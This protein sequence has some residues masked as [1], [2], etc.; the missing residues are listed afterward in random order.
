MSLRR[1]LIKL[2]IL[3]KQNNSKSII[4]MNTK[5]M[6]KLFSESTSEEFKNSIDDKITEATEKGSASLKTEEDD[7]Q[8]TNVGDKV[9]IEDKV[10]KELTSVDN[11]ESDEDLK[12]EAVDITKKESVSQ[13]DVDVKVAEGEDGDHESGTVPEVK[14]EVM[15][16]I[17][18]AEKAG[19]KGKSFSIT[20]SNATPSQIASTLKAFSDE[21]FDAVN[22]EDEEELDEDEAANAADEI[23]EKANDLKA[24]AEEMNDEPTKEKAEEVKAECDSI[25]AY[26]D[27]YEGVIDSSEL[28]VY[29]RIFS[30]QADEIIE[31]QS[32]SEDEIADEVIEKANNL[33]DKAKELAK[34]PTK[35]KAEEVKA[36][37]D[38]VKKF[39]DSLEGVIDTTEVKV[40]CRIFSEQADEILE[41]EEGEAKAEETETSSE[42]TSGEGS[43]EK[44]EE[45]SEEEVK[46]EETS[47]E[48]EATEEDKAKAEAIESANK[49]FSTTQQLLEGSCAP[50]PAYEN[51]VGTRTFSDSTNSV[52]TTSSNPFLYTNFD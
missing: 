14:I 21:G 26:C 33:K 10:N 7:L 16:G 17:G 6:L 27:K 38:S 31:K 22:K 43:E 23:L 24:M 51:Q 35:E 8:F 37:C 52:D 5:L 20:L 12:L 19:V 25:K 1:D 45:K 39:C 28:R 2:V 32:E 18:N 46:A 42:E 44:S 15:E 40:Y 47:T 11:P 48:G 50:C 49:T 4:F 30:E 41:K 13:P 36:E 9:L 3:L 34:E 29:C